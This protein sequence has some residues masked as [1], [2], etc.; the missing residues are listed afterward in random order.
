MTWPPWSGIGFQT[1]SSQHSTCVRWLNKAVDQWTF[2]PQTTPARPGL[3][4]VAHCDVLL[5]PL[6][7]TRLGRC[8]SVGSGKRSIFRGPR[9]SSLPSLSYQV[10]SHSQMM[11]S[12]LHRKTQLEQKIRR[13]DKLCTVCLTYGR[14]A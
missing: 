8:T 11:G 7:Q 10:L 4:L 13:S 1:A 9:P 14:R 3:D 5:G 12:C 6:L 2:L